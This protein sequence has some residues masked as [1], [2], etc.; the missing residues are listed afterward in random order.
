M[1]KFQ[2]NEDQAMFF[3]QYDSA[4]QRVATFDHLPATKDFICYPNKSGWKVVAGTVDS[5]GFKKDATYY[6]VDAKNIVT[7]SKKKFDTIQV[8]SMAR[9]LYNSSIA[10]SKLNM[11]VSGWKK[12]SKINLD[13]SITIWNFPDADASGNIWYGPECTWYYS[14]N[15]RVPVTSKI[16]NKVPL[17]SGKSGAVLNLSCPTEKMPTIGLIWLAH[18]YKL[19]Y[20]EINIS[21]KTGTSTLHYN[22]AE[23]TYAWDHVAN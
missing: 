1:K 19:S 17:M 12:F 9:A 18:R 7:I 14:S 15:G 16:V 2:A 23:K 20:N 13:Q 22:V 5:S 3:L 11:K 6:M 8:A 10:L 21:Y 4:W